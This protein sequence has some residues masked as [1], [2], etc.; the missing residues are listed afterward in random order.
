MKQ[1]TPPK[2]SRP[3]GSNLNQVLTPLG[4]AQSTPSNPPVADGLESILEGAQLKLD[5]LETTLAF[6]GNRIGSFEILTQPMDGS[7]LIARATNI[8]HRISMLVD[9]MNEVNSNL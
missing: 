2:Q 1:S 5:S 3:S 6:T 8:R 7:N 9:A 4:F